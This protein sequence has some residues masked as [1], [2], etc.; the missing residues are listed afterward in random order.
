VKLEND[1]LCA[2]YGEIILSLSHKCYDIFNGKI[3]EALFGDKS[4]IS[5]SFSNNTSGDIC[6]LSIPLDGSVKPIV[7]KRKADSNLFSIDYL[8]QFEGTFGN[9][10]LLY[11]VSLRGNKL[12]MSG[13]GQECELVPNKRL[14]F[15]LK[16]FPEHSI[17]FVLDNEGKVSELLFIH[18]LGSLNFKINQ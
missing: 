7:F 15:S 4:M 18:P 5:F 1:R 13:M 3:D 2:T 14:K 12:I 8:K 17:Q 10:P 16:G 6:E 11:E 9:D